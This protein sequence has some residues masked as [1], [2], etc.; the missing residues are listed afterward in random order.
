MSYILHGENQQNAVA[1]EWANGFEVDTESS[2]VWDI[3]RDTET[4]ITT[5][6]PKSG[7]YDYS[8]IALHGIGASAGAWI[9]R[10]IPYDKHELFPRKAR[11]IIPQAPTRFVTYLDREVSAWFDITA[12]DEYVDGMT[13]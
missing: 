5:M 12:N 4:E 7:D 1:D 10:L 13:A 3:S 9:R 11:I 2:D 6:M 8:I